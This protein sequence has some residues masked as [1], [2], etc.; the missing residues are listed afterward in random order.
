[1]A[2]DFNADQNR[3][4]LALLAAAGPSA[5]PMSFGQ[6]MF[7]GM[8]QHD[9]YLREKE[10]QEM[11]RKRQ[12]TQE[13]LIA[14][15]MQE[16]QA[17]AEQRRAQIAAMQQKAAEEKDLAAR[18]AAFLS[19]GMGTRTT[20]Q[21]ALA[22]GGGPTIGN[23]ARLNERQPFDIEQAIALFGIDNAQKMAGAGDWGRP[24]VARV[25]NGMAGGREVAQQFDKFGRP[26]GTGMEQY[27]APISVNQGNKTTFAD[28]FSLKTLQEFQQF[29]SPDSV[30]S[31]ATSRRGQD[32]VD[33]R[34]REG[35]A[36][37]MQNGK[38]PQ[39]YRM[40]LDG[41]LEAIPGGPA[42]IKAG[43][44]RAKAEQKKTSTLDQVRSVLETVKEA[45]DLVGLNTAGYGG[46]LANLPATEARDLQNKLV[47]I[48][49]NLGFDRLQQMRDQSPTGGA[50][51]QVAV[52]EINALQATV[53]SLDQ[54]QS[55]SQLKASLDKIDRHYRRWQEIVGGSSGGATGDYG[56]KPKQVTRT[57]TLNGRKVVQY[58]DGSTEYAD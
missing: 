31:N 33:M 7:M 6:R 47:T 42:D 43:E 23:A 18:Q 29:Q 9:Q 22:G 2:I 17:Q 55:P 32:M 11:L 36:I 8:G 41:T 38:I 27:R 10:A 26:V 4:G 40:K 57:G 14:A 39:D 44:A 5:R 53:S 49:A 15:Q 3:M 13:L 56:D 30:A 48:K 45:K 34:S 51:G 21:Q 50:L 54:Q 19:G 46:Y 52:Q 37:T 24:E 28:P 25:V 58:S 35:N 16:M 12:A 20:P 1:M